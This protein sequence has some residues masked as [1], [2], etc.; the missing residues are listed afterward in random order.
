MS[1]VYLH[2]ALNK[3]EIKICKDELL[4]RPC[5]NLQSKFHSGH[6]KRIKFAE[7]Y[8]IIAKRCMALAWQSTNL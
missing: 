3:C 8:P 6:C 1:F 4:F 2:L 7:F 5:E